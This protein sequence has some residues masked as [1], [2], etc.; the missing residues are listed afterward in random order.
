MKILA[1]DCGDQTGWASLSSGVESG[2][3]N[4]KSRYGEGSGMR[5]SNF[6]TWLENMLDKNVCPDLVI[7]EMAHL[8]G[9]AASEILSG[10]ITR[11]QEECDRRK[12]NYTFV[13][14]GTLKKWATEKGNASK[15]EMVR[16]AKKR[17]GIKVKD[18][19]EADALLLLDYA[20]EKNNLILIRKT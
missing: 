17:F 19:N 14:S 12:I 4:F 13:H 3:I 2:S 8:R 11:I 7:Y 15:A 6:R 5:Y 18:D 10:Y 16:E 1:I 9:R 20:R